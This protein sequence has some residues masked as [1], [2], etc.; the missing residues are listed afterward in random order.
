MSNA[1]RKE[2]KECPRTAQAYNNKVLNITIQK[3][4]KVM[5]KSALTQLLEKQNALATKAMTLRQVDGN[6]KA[7]KIYASIESED[8]YTLSVKYG[9]TWDS[10]GVCLE[11]TAEKKSYGEDQSLHDNREAYDLMVEEIGNMI[12]AIEAKANDVIS[13]IQSYNLKNTIA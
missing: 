5:E 2:N 9:N 4:D 11:W 3:H 7:I 10:D 8:S 6:N 12:A 1:G 13:T